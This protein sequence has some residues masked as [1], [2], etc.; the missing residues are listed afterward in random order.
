[1]LI[2]FLI[3]KA[4]GGSTHY[5]MI[6]SLSKGLFQKAIPMSGSAFCKA[7]SQIPKR[8]WSLRLAKNLGYTGAANDKDLLEFLEK[9]DGMAIVQAAK[10]VLTF[11][12]EIGLHILYAFG[13]VVE[14]Y[15]SDNCFI[16]EDPILMAREAWS[17]DVDLLIGATSNEGILRAN[18]DAESISKLLQNVNFFAPVNE[19][20]IDECSDKAKKYGQRIMDVYYKGSKPSANNQQPY[21]YV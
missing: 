2:K 5:H 6:S 1:M 18:S 4:G 17:K 15:I 10:K 8:D 13:P 7:W 14:P 9:P 16:P 20:G 11:E 19:L 3:V 21:L 12:E